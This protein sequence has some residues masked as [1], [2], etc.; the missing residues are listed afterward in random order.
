MV[1]AE[2]LARSVV[3]ARK[4]TT[5]PPS[6]VPLTP[7]QARP[8]TEHPPTDDAARLKRKGHRLGILLTLISV[9]LLAIGIMNDS[10]YSPPP[11]ASF[12]AAIGAGGVLLSYVFAR[13][14]YWFKAA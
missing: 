3:Y 8:M 2:G 6:G 4:A 14:W 7:I 1:P 9:V 12:F 13:L 10:G 5:C 11:W